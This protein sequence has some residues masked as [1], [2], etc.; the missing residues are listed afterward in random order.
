MFGGRLD[1]TDSLICSRLILSNSPFIVEQGD[2]GRPVGDILCVLLR[3]LDAF[4]ESPMSPSGAPTLSAAARLTLCQLPG[5]RFGIGFAL[6]NTSELGPL[7]SFQHGFQNR[8]KH[9]LK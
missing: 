1:W 7:E 9:D 6:P 8:S 4:G 5:L 2:F 3:R